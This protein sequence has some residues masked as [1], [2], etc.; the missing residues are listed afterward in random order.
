MNKPTALRIAKTAIVLAV[1]ASPMA[2]AA[3]EVE[4]GLSEAQTQILTYIG[5]AIAA[6]FALLTAS[7]APDV[8]MTLVKKWIKKGAK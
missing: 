2:F 4:A 8:G 1:A 7:L 3:G 5:L 6:G